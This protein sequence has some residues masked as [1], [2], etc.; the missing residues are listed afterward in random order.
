MVCKW[1]SREKNPTEFAAGP[2]IDVID[3]DTTNIAISCDVA[4]EDDLV[5]AIW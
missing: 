1:I 5:S 3:K 2:D 4:F